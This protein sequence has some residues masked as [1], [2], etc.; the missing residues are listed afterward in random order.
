M[1]SIWGRRAH[2]PPPGH[3]RRTHTDLVVFSAQLLDTAAS[4]LDAPQSLEDAGVSLAFGGHIFTATPGLAERIPGHYLGDVLQ[5]V[6]YVIE[7]LGPQPAAGPS[8][9][10]G[11]RRIPPRLGLFPRAGQLIETQLWQQNM[12][13]NGNTSDFSDISHYL[14]RNISSAL[15]LGDL[16][17]V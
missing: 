12:R 6:P 8:C 5:Q 17:F 2:Q 13:W 11:H 1:W 16:D 3:H 9:A 7:Q 15:R 10:A 4:L 14:T